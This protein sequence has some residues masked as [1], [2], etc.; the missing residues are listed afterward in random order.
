VVRLPVAV[1]PVRWRRCAVLLT[2]VSLAAVAGVVAAGS[3]A[4]NRPVWMA[5]PLVTVARYPFDDVGPGAWADVTGN[6][7]TLGPV[8]SNGAATSRVPHASGRALRFPKPCDVEPCPRLALQAAS[9]AALNPGARL[10]RYGA[11][12]L[13]QPQDTSDGQ[14][15][16]QKGYSAEGSQYKLQIDGRAGRPSCALLGDSNHRIYLAIAA[17]SVADGAWHRLECRRD[18]GTLTLLVNN[19]PQ[20]STPVPVSLSIVN[21]RPLSLGGKSAYG[22]NDQYHG[23]LDD[24][25]IAVG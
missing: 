13:L 18:P 15:I 17:I 23:L 6:D 9:T 3:G 21:D 8:V 7:H 11:S 16:L 5:P 12:V 1:L 20:A 4:V 14:N 25:W 22:D 2:V 24:V 10:L 19:R